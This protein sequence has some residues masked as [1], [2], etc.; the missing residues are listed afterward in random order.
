MDEERIVKHAELTSHLSTICK[1]MDVDNSGDLSKENIFGGF[2]HNEKFRSTLQE[3]NITEE[4]LEILWTILDDSKTGRVSY[5]SFIS[6]CYNMRASDMKFV[7]A[8]IKYTVLIIKDKI[9][10]QMAQ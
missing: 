8:H 7:L 10:E 6:H 9:C 2:E 3:M 1:E 4:D 5:D